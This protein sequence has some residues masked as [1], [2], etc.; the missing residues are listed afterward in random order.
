MEQPIPTWR[1]GADPEPIFAA[2]G[3]DGSGLPVERYDLGP[4]HVY[5]ELG[6]P[7]EVAALRPDIAALARATSDGVNCFAHATGSA[8]RRGCSR[9]SHGVA[10][11]PATGSAAGPLAIHLARHGRI[12]FGEQ[13]EISQGA[14]LEPPLDALRR[15]RGS[16]D[17]IERV[18]V[19]GSAVD[20]R[21]R[22]VQ[23]LSVG[24]DASISGSSTAS[25]LQ[26][27]PPFRET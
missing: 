5:V 4:G 19:G 21:A 8:G 9:P 12:A 15:G 2:L 24:R 7:E 20:R 1:A 3:V 25:A 13:I 26:K 6:S 16:A 10:E 17:R 27:T 18:V 22:R 23:L 11:D 14:E